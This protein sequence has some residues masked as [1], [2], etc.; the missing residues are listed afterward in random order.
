MEQRYFIPG[1]IEE[2]KS[3]DG[4]LL[5]NN[6]N[7]AEILLDDE[8]LC[9]YNAIKKDGLE[10]IDTKF[11]QCLLEEEI[12]V[13]SE[14]QKKYAEIL[15]DIL[16]NTLYLT[17][18]PTESCNF[19]CIYCYE[20]HEIVKMSMDTVKA[21]KEYTAALCEQNT[22][23]KIV[24]LWFGGEP[25]LCPE[26][27]E[28]VSLHLKSIAERKYIPFLSS[29]TTNAYLLSKDLFEKFLA[30]GIT[31]Y[32]ITVD[33]YE[34]DSRRV[35]CNGEPT[36]HKILENLKEISTLDPKI[37][38][39][40][41]L[42]RNLLAQDMSYDWY[43]Y[44]KKEFGKDKRFHYSVIPVVCNGG[45]NDKNLN[46]IK[47]GNNLIQ[48]HFAYLKSKDMQITPQLEPEVLGGVCFAGYRHGYLF[49]ADG[50]IGKCTIELYN[51]LNYIGKIVNGI[52]VIDSDKF[53]LWNKNYFDE[54][55]SSCRNALLCFNKACPMN[56]I[57][58]RRYTCI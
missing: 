19:R 16:N 50:T 46:V 17:I 56:H 57:Q 31:S 14:M 43:D 37:D 28:N 45:K 3:T 38:F 48:K 52:V 27:V 5:K 49:R 34:H 39:N 32:Q 51:P 29:M 24:L 53:D 12:L 2:K 55:C 6:F 8:E 25:T 23:K 22:I 13:T 11:A 44:L 26:I 36:L 10:T 1:Y 20:T 40:I 15:E 18:M 21:I 47:K 35:L 41:M 33:G 9:L 58:G 42:R 54:K 4:L 7:G 30:A